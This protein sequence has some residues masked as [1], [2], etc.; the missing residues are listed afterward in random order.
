VRLGDPRST[1]GKEVIGTVGEPGLAGSCPV[2]S[3]VRVNEVRPFGR[4]DID[5]PNVVTGNE[6]PIDPPLVG[7]NVD[8]V[9]FTGL[10][11]GAVAR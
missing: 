5:K 8:A 9:A 7:R 2:G 1:Q 11:A 3:E 6:R 10:Q 4:F